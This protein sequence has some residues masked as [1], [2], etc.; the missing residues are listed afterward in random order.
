MDPSSNDRSPVMHSYTLQPV[1]PVQLGKD[2]PSQASVSA[3][4]GAAATKPSFGGHLSKHKKD[5]RGFPTL[6]A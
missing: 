2:P 1:F 5:L 6:C 3:N 4:A